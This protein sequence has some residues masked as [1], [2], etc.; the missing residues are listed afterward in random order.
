[1]S[2]LDEKEL[3]ALKQQEQKKAAAFHDLGVLEAQKHELLHFLASVQS[4]QA[5]SKKELEEKYG[6]INIDLSD[7]SY[8]IIA[9][10][11]EQVE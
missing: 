5:D 11:V 3:E 10:E 1:M 7:G 6:K 8:E 9:E 2:K 4:E